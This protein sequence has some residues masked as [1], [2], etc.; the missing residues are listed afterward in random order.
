MR[1]KIVVI[2]K[3]AGEESGEIKLIENKLESFQKIVGGY[4]ETAQLTDE[5]VLICDEEG[6]L[7]NKPYNMTINGFDFVGDIVLAGIKDGEFCDIPMALELR[8]EGGEK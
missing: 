6:R 1:K 7:K 2:V 5:V 4:I 3:K 8:A